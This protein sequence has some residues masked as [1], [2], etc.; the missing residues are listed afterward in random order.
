MTVKTLIY[1]GCLIGYQQVF[2]NNNISD[3]GISAYQDLT[4]NYQL[5]DS[6]LT[7]N[8]EDELN[9]GA[10][11]VYEYDASDGTDF[12]GRTSAIKWD[13]EGGNG[14]KRCYFTSLE[15]F[16]DHEIIMGPKD[17][18]D[19]VKVWVNDTDVDDDLRVIVYQ[20]CL[21]LYSAGSPSITFHLIENLV[22]SIGFDVR[23]FSLSKSYAGRHDSCKMMVRVRFGSDNQDCAQSPDVTLQKFRAQII[24]NDLIFADG[25]DLIF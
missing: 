5:N 9:K 2:A 20:T 16:A 22:T 8:N 13:S 6:N 11:F 10:M 1:L 15:S 4:I 14:V 24:Q 19:A 23:G 12:D 25:L 7:M 18:L 17:V 21:P 3:E